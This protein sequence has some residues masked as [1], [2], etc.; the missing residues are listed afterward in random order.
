MKASPANPVQGASSSF[1]VAARHA[2][3]QIACGPIL[4]EVERHAAP[5]L[6]P[7]TSMR[8][9]EGRPDFLGDEGRIGGTL[10]NAGL[11]DGSEQGRSLLC[12][13]GAQEYDDPAEKSRRFHERIHRCSYTKEIKR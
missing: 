5:G 1:R 3:E 13:D 12:K 2:K 6:Q 4:S 8:A 7:K 11:L 9:L 10:R